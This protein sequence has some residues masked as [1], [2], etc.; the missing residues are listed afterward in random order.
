MSSLTIQQSPPLITPER[1]E[2]RL[3]CYHGDNNYPYMLWYRHKSA[4]GGQRDLELIGVL[5]YE[6]TNFEE[7]FEA[8]FN[9]TGHSKGRAQ[10]VISNTNPADSAEYFCAAN[11]CWSLRPNYISSLPSVLA[12]MQCYQNHTNSKKSALLWTAESFS[13]PIEAE[14]LVRR[15][16]SPFNNLLPR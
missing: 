14:S 8:R 10:L 16:P 1:E 12:E 2:A 5:H 4:A 11:V 13:V 9:M 7:N 15:A 3:D 6:K